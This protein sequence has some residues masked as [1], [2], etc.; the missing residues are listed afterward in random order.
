MHDAGKKQRDKDSPKKEKSA[1]MKSS[2]SD[3]NAKSRI[4]ESI[5]RNVSNAK[6]YVSPENK[7][8]RNPDHKR[9]EIRAIIGE[10]QA[11]RHQDI[12]HFYEVKELSG[13]DK[14]LSNSNEDSANQQLADEKC[15]ITINEGNTASFL[16]T[17]VITNSNKGNNVAQ[18]DY[19]SELKNLEAK[20][21]EES[22]LNS[23]SK[24]NKK[25]MPLSF[26]DIKFNDVSQ[27]LPPGL[28]IFDPNTSTSEFDFFNEPYQ[29]NVL[30]ASFN[31]HEQKSAES[32]WQPVVKMASVNKL[33]P[34]KTR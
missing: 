15:A 17:L 25:G 32:S 33:N 3:S 29:D 4:S 22:T 23:T 9:R 31:T 30:A 7:T 2:E 13:E 26:G 18:A 8:V 1:T 10:N 6:S 21:N 20:I 34:T 14:N 5:L 28:N 19:I 12:C 11:L 27:R 24:V 16:S